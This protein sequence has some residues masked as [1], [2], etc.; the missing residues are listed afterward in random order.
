MI[1]C[2]FGLPRWIR[3]AEYAQPKPTSSTRSADVMAISSTQRAM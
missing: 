2:D 3:S 1:V